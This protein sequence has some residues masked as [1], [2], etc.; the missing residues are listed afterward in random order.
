MRARFQIFRDA[1][2]QLR[3]RFRARNGEIVAQSEAYT[4][5]TA[6]LNGIEVIKREAGD[7]DTEDLA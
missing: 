3:W 6:C 1:Q 7:A 5:K 4:S 2:N